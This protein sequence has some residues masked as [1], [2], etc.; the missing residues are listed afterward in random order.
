MNEMLSTL[1]LID[2]ASTHFVADEAL[3]DSDIWSDK[4]A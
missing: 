4:L 1:L 2:G 3:S